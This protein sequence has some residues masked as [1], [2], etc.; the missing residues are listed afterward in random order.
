MSY[1]KKEEQNTFLQQK[2][3]AVTT[4]SLIYGFK[5]KQSG[6]NGFLQP[7]LVITGNLM[8]QLVSLLL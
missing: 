7:W 8:H 4:F 1:W 5:I 6:V 2:W 3:E